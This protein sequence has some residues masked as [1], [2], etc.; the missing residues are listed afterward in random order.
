M[1]AWKRS[2]IVAV[3]A[4]FVCVSVYLNWSYN[5]G[6]PEAVAGYEQFEDELTSK[7]ENEDSQ[8]TGK[9]DLGGQQTSGNYFANARLTRQQSRDQALT[10]LKESNNESKMSELANCSVVET[11]IENLVIA[12]GYTDCVAFINDGTIK[13]V[14]SAPENGLTKQD[15]AKIKEIALSETKLTADDV[16]IVEV[17]Y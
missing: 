7:I 13:I 4:V 14:V 16:T 5:Q 3:V 1:K 10:I 12:K 11:Q 17:K 15:A 6:L 2:A 8:A 9:D